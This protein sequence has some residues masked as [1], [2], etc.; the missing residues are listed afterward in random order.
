MSKR[1]DTWNDI[2]ML[3]DKLRVDNEVLLA[4]LEALDEFDDP[5][6]E[7]FSWD[8]F[9]LEEFPLREGPWHE[10]ELGER[11]WGD[12]LMNAHHN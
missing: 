1:S 3:F 7:E 2:E 10:F 8:E 5:E 6:A 9:T 12:F 4:I 11:P